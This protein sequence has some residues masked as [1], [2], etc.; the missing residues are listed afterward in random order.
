MTIYKVGCKMDDAAAYIEYI[1][2]NNEENAA[3]IYDKIYHNVGYYKEFYVK[4][5]GLFRITTHVIRVPLLSSG[6]EYKI[7]KKSWKPLSWIM[8]V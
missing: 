3:M 8:D 1:D 6:I 5:F 2:A 7:L 4:K